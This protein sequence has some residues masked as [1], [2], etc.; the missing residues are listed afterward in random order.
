MPRTKPITFNGK[1]QSVAEWAEELHVAPVTLYKR[2]QAYSLD[3]AMTCGKLRNSVGKKPM[4]ITFNGKTQSRSQWCEELGIG[5]STFGHR[6]Q[7]Y[8]L[9]EV[10]SFGKRIK[11]KKEQQCK[12][13]TKMVTF[14]GQTLTIAGW[15]KKL[16]VCRVTIY[17]RL[18]RLPIEKAL[19]KKLIKGASRG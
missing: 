3:V 16:Q 19:N 8:S 18:E 5:L 2:L 12:R 7:K 10:M 1:T 14:K 17:K 9:E 6:L 15:A 4:L 13:T 11:P